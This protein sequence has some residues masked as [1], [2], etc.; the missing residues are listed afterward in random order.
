M[1]AC[2][3]CGMHCTPMADYEV[4]VCAVCDARHEDAVVRLLG[5][6]LP[7]WAASLADLVEPAAAAALVDAVMPRELYGAAGLRR[8]AS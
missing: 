7:E 3:L 2:C 1:T 6:R 8:A 5:A 4:P